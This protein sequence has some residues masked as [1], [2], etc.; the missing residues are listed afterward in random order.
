[1][2]DLL[3]GA[4]IEQT[5]IDRETGAIAGPII[6]NQIRHLRCPHPD[7]PVMYVDLDDLKTVNDT[8][9]HAAGD[10]LIARAG[11]IIRRFTRFTDDLY[12]G[13][14]LLRVGGDEFVVLFD[15]Q[16]D[17]EA[18]TSI[19]QRFVDIFDGRYGVCASV[20]VVLA[21]HRTIGEAIDEA[22]AAMYEAKRARKA[23][24]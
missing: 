5:A 14:H 2:N 24:R 17:D 6:R 8:L 7:M 1:M 23:G 20:G 9:G 11:R 16:A 4:T 10:Q 3:T 13:S 19:R 18:L 21:G 12:D 22:D 15:T